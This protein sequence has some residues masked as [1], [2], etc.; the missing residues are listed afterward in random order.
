MRFPKYWTY[1]WV[2]FSISWV[3]YII[4]LPFLQNK[5]HCFFILVASVRP[6]IVSCSMNSKLEFWQ[7]R[8]VGSIFTEKTGWYQRAAGMRSWE[9]PPGLAQ[10]FS[11]ERRGGSRCSVLPESPHL[12]H[13]GVGQRMQPTGSSLADI[14]YRP[15][16]R[17][18][19]GLL[20]MATG[21]LIPW[22]LLVHS[23]VNLVKPPSPHLL[24][25]FPRSLL[26][27]AQQRDWVTCPRSHS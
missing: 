26:L 15:N 5:I 25:P 2:I 11:F 23:S 6:Q 18:P 16:L 4:H 8:V 27:S 22:L 7:K 1:F 13:P 17:S 24:R 9:R 10:K 3:L 19:F 12:C 21:L 20:Q 14:Y